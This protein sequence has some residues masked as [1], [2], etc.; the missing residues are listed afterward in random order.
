ME[1]YSFGNVDIE[2]K[3]NK[4]FLLMQMLYR[5]D[6]IENKINDE[7]NALSHLAKLMENFKKILDLFQGV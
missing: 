2:F 4:I 6:R 1:N 5:W 3:T 7:D